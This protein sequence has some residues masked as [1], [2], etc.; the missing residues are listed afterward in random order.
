MRLARFGRPGVSYLDFPANV[1]QGRVLS[2]SIP[3]QYITD[4]VPVTYPDPN[5]IANAA[6]LLTKAE[7]PLIIVGKG[8]AYA[9]AEKELQE[10]VSVSNLPFL[11]TPMGKGNF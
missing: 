11:P 10:L 5:K 1:L 8:A 9:R 3:T 7:N 6:S 4:I 2:T